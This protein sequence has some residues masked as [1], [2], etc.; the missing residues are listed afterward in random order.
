MTVQYSRDRQ[1]TI[2]QIKM[3]HAKSGECGKKSRTDDN[4]SAKNMAAES[5][6]GRPSREQ[7]GTKRVNC[8]VNNGYQ[9]GLGRIEKKSVK[10]PL[11]E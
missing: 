3:T 1:R 8:R 5:V 2:K 4:F 10:S 6:K 11:V 9:N 7:S